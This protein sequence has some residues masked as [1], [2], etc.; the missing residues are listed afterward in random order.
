MNKIVFTVATYYPQTNGVQKVTEYQAEGLAKKGYEVVVITSEHPSAPN[1]EIHHGVTI[2]RMNAHMWHMLHIGNKHEFQDRVLKECNDC[3]VLINVCSESFAS[4]WCL[5][6]LK[7]LNCKKVL[8]QHG[9]HETKPILARRQSLPDKAKSLAQNIRWSLFYFR[10]NAYFR[11]YDLI[12]HLHQ[13]DKSLAWARSIGI[14]NN[15]VLP[16][17]AED[18]FFTADGVGCKQGIISV[19]TYCENKNQALLLRAYYKA[20][21]SEPLTLIGQ[22]DNKYYS[23]LVSLN[24]R[25]SKEYGARPVSILCDTPRNEVIKQIKKSKIYVCTS[26]SEHYPVSIVE[27]MACGCCWISRDVGIV[28]YLPGGIVLHS[29]NDLPAVLDSVLD[30]ESR[31]RSLAEKGRCYALNNLREEVVLDKLENGLLNLLR[32]A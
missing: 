6:L 30:N 25:L 13:E 21:T 31:L 22:S 20:S 8:V 7:R 23:Y 9:M 28:K 11:Y 5:D 10:N 14:S 26:K 15:L 29:D 12:T 18:A 27:A 32:E 16:N 24:E 19:G 3:D 2:Y 4:A 17:A 1:F